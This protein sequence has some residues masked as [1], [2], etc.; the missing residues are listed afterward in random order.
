MQGSANMSV[1][2][3]FLPMSFLISSKTSLWKNTATL[4]APIYESIKR[5]FKLSSE[6]RSNN[7]ATDSTKFD[8]LPVVWKPPGVTWPEIRDTLYCASARRS[9]YGE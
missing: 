6:T 4:S 7:C 8:Q 9:K 2:L 1:Y 3:L 5:L